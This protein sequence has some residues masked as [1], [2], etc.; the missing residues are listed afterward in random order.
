[1]N[2]KLIISLAFLLLSLNSFC[3]IVNLDN[4]FAIFSGKQTNNE[5]KF[6]LAYAVGALPEITYE[7]IIEDNM[8][9]GIS[10]AVSLESAEDNPY[11]YSI[12]PYYRL[13]FGKKKASG[14]FIEGNMGVIG[15]KEE[16]Y[17]YNDFYGYSS[18]SETN[19]YV[20]FG[21]GVAVGLKLFTRNNYFGE[22]YGG[23]VRLIGKSDLGAYPRFGITLG[24]RF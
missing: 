1:M 3:Q 7:R 13:Y 9:L 16:Q 21:C 22:I 2:R 4:P 8:G 10:A 19:S 14:F 15:T 11:R 20:N 6:N 5:L 18:R 23:A 17:I 24:K 12:L